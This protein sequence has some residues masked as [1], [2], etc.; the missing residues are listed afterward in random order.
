MGMKDDIKNQ[1][2]TLLAPGDYDIKA[3]TTVPG[4]GDNRLT[5]GNTGVRFDAVTLYIDMRGSTAVL[6]AHRA[7]SVAKIHKAYLF[8]ATKVIAARDGAI[9][10][11]NGDSILAFFPG[12]GKAE[13][14]RAIKCAMEIKFM[15][16][17]ECAG[18]FGRYSPVDFGIG[19]DVGPVLCVKAGMG[20]N[21]N[22]N[23]LLWLG[24]AVNRATTLS[25]KARDPNQV[26][27]SQAVRDLQNDAVRTSGG[28]DMWTQR[29]AQYN[30]TSEVAWSTNYGW[31]VS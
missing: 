28:K 22:H 4:P 25:D 2:A 26:W 5:F 8:V 27:V 17:Q 16:A 21:D 29:A 30:G 18:E 20:R 14:E 6:N 11:Y 13:V 24:N 19:L 9:R 7:H 10:S 1:V 31:Q 23:D 12:N 3:S 15:L